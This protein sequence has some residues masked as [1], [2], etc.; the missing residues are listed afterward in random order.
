M[1]GIGSS[2]RLNVFASLKTKK[3]PVKA[4][5]VNIQ[6]SL[7]SLLDVNYSLVVTNTLQFEYITS[8]G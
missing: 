4:I 7:T 6:I 1:R 5:H 2:R 8:G 3:G